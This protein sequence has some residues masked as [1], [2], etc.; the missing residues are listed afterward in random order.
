M[1]IH[2]KIVWVYDIESFPNCFTCTVKNTERGQLY[3]FEVSSRKNQLLELVDFFKNSGNILMCGYN[4]KGYDDLIISY[5]IGYCQPL[6]RNNYLAV[7]ASIKH[8][9]D[10]II[11]AEKNDDNKRFAHW[12]YLNYFESMDLLRM[13][14]SSKLRVGLKE[15]QITM[16]YPNVQEYDGDFNKPIPDSE[17]DHMIEYN[18]NDVNSTEELLNCLQKKGEIDV[19]LFMENEYGI[20]ALSM[21]SVKFGEEMLLNEY[22]KKTG[23][24][25]KYVQ[26]LRSPMDYVP[27]KDVILPIIQYKN[28]ILQDVL[29]ELKQQVVPTR[30]EL[31]PK[32]QK[33]YEKRFYISKTRYS[34]GVGGIHSINTPEIFV[35]K[36]D[37]YIGHAD[38]TSMYPSFIVQYGWVPRHLGKEFWTIYTHVY[39]ERIEA[40]HSGEK[41]KSTALKLVLNSVTGKMQQETSWMYDPFTVFKIRING[42]LVLLMLVDRLLALNCR[43]VQVN[44][45]GVMYVARKD[46]ESRVQEA[47]HEVEQLTKLGFETDSYEAFYQYAVND[48]FGVIEGYSQ[49]KNPKLIEKKGM[50]ITEPKLGKGLAP[51]VIP[52]AVINYFLT[53]QDVSEFIRNDKDINDFLMTQRADRKFKVF[54]GDEPVTRINRYYA[55]EGGR[56]LFKVGQDGKITNMLTKSGVTILNKYDDKPIENRKINYCY[57]SSEARKIIEDLVC[58]QLELF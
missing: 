46:D 14:F 31:I 50:F 15:M 3:T 54:Y 5:I 23:L 48:Y 36:E 27:L 11:E 29:E 51:L 49:S 28:P 39:H 10:C 58:R 32:G 41:T 18:I 42:Q 55:S 33:A 38:V 40:K 45:D 20:N 24:N 8:M 4:N 47:I 43:I 21:D 12:K 22:C 17:I 56:Y 2:N 35:P 53:K 16:F 25:K 1:V 19:R 44:T 13:M 37:E 9:S 52:K 26:S 6:S 34:V 30:K 7:C 57:Y